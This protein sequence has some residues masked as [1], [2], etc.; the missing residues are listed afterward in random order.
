MQCLLCSGELTQVYK[1]KTEIS[2]SSDCKLIKDS[3]AL[4]QCAV[5]GHIQKEINE[6]Y[7]QQINDLYHNYTAYPLTE[8]KEQLQFTGDVPSTRTESIL[9]NCEP[10]LRD[11]RSNLKW[12]DVGA[13]SGVMLKSISH[14]YPHFSLWGQDVSSCNATQVLRIKNVKG[15][16]QGELDNIQDQKFDVISIIHVLEHVIEP[17]TFL[18]QLSKLLSKNGILIIQVPDIQTNIMDACIYDH[19]SHFQLPTLTSLVNRIFKHVDVP[20]T[21]IGKELTLLVSNR[22]SS[23]RIGHQLEGAQVFVPDFNHLIKLNEQMV[24]V[25]QATAVFSTGPTGV[26]AGLCLGSH[27]T[28]FVDED[29]NKIGKHYLGVPILSPKDIPKGVTVISP[30]PPEQT[31]N[32]KLRYQDIIF[33]E[34]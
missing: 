22:Q 24:Q 4:H 13:G 2:V 9:H 23:N 12:L 31:H 18:K 16:Y 27:L 20:T 8:G 10:Y 19:V 3:P 14:L 17:I 5:C 34:L 15:F 32:L 28:C 29:P 1:A 21:Q 25:K 33:Q 11:L 26:Y 6:S 7:L 30:L